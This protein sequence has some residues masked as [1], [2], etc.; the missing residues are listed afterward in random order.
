MLFLQRNRKAKRKLKKLL[1]NDQSILYELGWMK[2]LNTGIPQD[3]DGN[4]IPWMNY[5]ITDFIRQRARK[6]L[7]LFEY[8]SGYSTLWFSQLFQ[9]VVSVEYDKNW[10]E[11]IKQKIPN[12][13]T[14]KFQ[15]HDIDGKYCRTVANAIY[16][17]IIVDGRDRVNCL[18]QSLFSVSKEGIIILDDSERPYYKEGIDFLT[19]NGFR[20]IEFKSLKPT[21]HRISAAT[22]FY[23]NDNCF[24]I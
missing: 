4:L 14:L 3:K 18:K 20:K 5:Q 8:G 2:T 6:E 21:S 22:V 15:E 11:K 13:V 23:R 10:H 9:K 17:I 16:D 1:I 24:G 12:N 7:S 19:E